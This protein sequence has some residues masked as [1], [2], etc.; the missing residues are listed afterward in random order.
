MGLFIK[1]MLSSKVTAVTNAIKGIGGVISTFRT[2]FYTN[3]T[4]ALDD[5]NFVNILPPMIKGP[6]TA[7][8]INKDEAETL[9]E[10]L[11]EAAKFIEAHYAKTKGLE[12]NYMLYTLFNTVTCPDEITEIKNNI[13][14]KE[15]YFAEHNIKPR[16]K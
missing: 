6:L 4:D 15:S 1:K 12:K 16:Y 8:K 2:F 5:F 3:K 10:Q 11:D 7:H 14:K 13:L 9:M